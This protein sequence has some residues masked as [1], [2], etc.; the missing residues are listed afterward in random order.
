VH[1]YRTFPLADPYLP[2]ALLPAKWHGRAAAALFDRQHAALAAPAERWVRTVCAA[3]D[4][5]ARHDARALR[6]AG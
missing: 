5:A 3:G 4:A 1:E 2:A 6:A